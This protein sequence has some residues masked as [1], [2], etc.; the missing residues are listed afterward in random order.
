MTSPKAV[1]KESLSIFEY[2]YEEGGGDGWNES[3]IKLIRAAIPVAKLHEEVVKMIFTQP[4]TDKFWARM[5]EIRHQLEA[6]K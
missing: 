3:I 6:L 5:H 4:H 1:L 2:P